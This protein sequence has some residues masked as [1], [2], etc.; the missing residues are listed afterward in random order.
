[1][2]PRTGRV[3]VWLILCAAVSL[4]AIVLP[5]AQAQEIRWLRVSELQSFVNSI[6]IEYEDEGTTGNTNFFSWPA[7][8]G[9]DQNVVRSKLVWIGCKNFN[10]P[11]ENKVLPVKVIGSGPRDFDDRRNQ[12]F[13]TQIKLIGRTSH[14]S[15][16][17]D[18]QNSS[19]L[20]QYDIVD[21]V[22][23]ALPCDRMVLVQFNTSI[24]VSVTKKVMVF[25]YPRQ[26]NYF[27]NDYVFKNTG[28]INAA[29]TV[30][31]QT[32]DSVWFYFAHR[33]AFAGVSSSGW[34]SSWGA[35]SSTWGSSTL[36]HAFGENPTSPD[37]TYGGVSL[38][39][40][41]S[42]YGQ[43]S[44]SNQSSL[45]YAEDWGCP[46][47]TGGDGMLGS[48]KYAGCLTLH[49]DTSPQNNADDLY[50]PKTTWY[51]GAD[52]QSMQPGSLSQYNDITMADRYTIM[53]ERHPPQQYDQAV[54][55][56]KYANNFTDA[57]R[58]NAMQGQGYGPY[59]LAPGDSIHIVYVEGVSGISWEKGTE[60]GGNWIKWRNST[61]Q[62]TLVM[63]DGSTTADYNLYKRQWVET[64]KD[65]L[66][67]TYHNAI[68]NYKSGY[69]LPQP[70]PPPASFAVAS[71]G[72]RI[73]LTWANNA[74]S[75]PH[76][77]G[78]VI[79]RS[80]GNVLDYRTTYQKIF[81]CDKATVVHEFSDVTA[82]RGFYYYYYIQSKDDG[83]Q[84]PGTVLYSSLF[85][86]ITMDPATLQRPAVTSTLDSVRVVPN[87]YDIRGRF[88]QFGDRSQYDQISVYGLP[89]VA[90]LK[91]YTERGDLIW[92][93]AHTTGTGDVL[94]TS[95]TTY[96]QIVA[97][98]IYILVVET[99]DNRTVIRK[100]VVLR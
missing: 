41:F 3:S 29:G 60:V 75:Y 12:I 49:A 43:N 7:Q 87:P 70:P 96:G 2:T 13:P 76:F 88:L 82:V 18:D 72:D 46:N 90:T 62:P 28:I 79:Y 14:P 36:H 100:V 19:V 74:D 42:W 53:S 69:A 26:G 32:L 61:G 33:Y 47:V 93:K 38:R 94:W 48:A 68:D 22:D 52:I 8:Y 66:L 73:Q 51:I 56:G 23:P 39:G 77:N 71:G 21:E 58:S 83:T 64:G 84:V 44:E 6:G 97:S 10:D 81:E 92:Q 63:P 1:M 5:V 59:R 17:V 9:I 78:Y 80:K 24:G 67:A 55:E 20:T 50:Q 65:S 40:F 91:I 30:Q 86:T 16:T 4:I 27:I 54:G 37:Y 11:V 57:R 34:G 99:P 35:F 15:V 98:G 45:S 89:P 25:A 95:E 85:L 31:Q